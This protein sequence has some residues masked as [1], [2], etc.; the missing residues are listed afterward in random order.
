MQRRLATIFLFAIILFPLWAHGQLDRY[1]YYFKTQK[2]ITRG[3]YTG[4]IAAINIFLNNQPDDDIALYLRALAKYNLEDYRGALQDLDR[5]LLHKPFTPEAL[6]LRGGCLNQLGESRRAMGDIRLAQELRPS[7][8]HIV[9]L[10]GV[11]HFLNQAYDSAACDF[12]STLATDPDNLD[13]RLNLGIAH[14]QLGDT[15]QALADFEHARRSHPYSAAPLVNLARVYYGQKQQ[16]EA[17]RTI[18]EALA[19]EKT[20][21][22]A[23]LLRALIEHDQGKVDQAI[24]TL[25]TV[26]R[27]APRSSLALFNRAIMLTEREKLPEALADYQA[28]QEISPSNVF[29]RFNR[30]LLH[31]QL[32]QPRRA[33]EAFTAAIQLLPQFARAYSLR[34]ETRLQLGD[35][36]GAKADFDSA[37]LLV[38]KHKGG[39]LDQWSDTSRQFNRLIAFE[40]D[41]SSPADV[42][43]PSSPKSIDLLPLATVAVGAVQPYSEWRPVLRADSVCGAP[44][45]SLV[46]PRE[47]TALRVNVNLF[48]PLPNGHAVTLVHAITL[49]EANDYN[50]A[51]AQLQQLPSDGVFAPLVQYLRAIALVQNARFEPALP[52]RVS[53][54]PT[55]GD[56]ATPP[57]SSDYQEPLRIL[58]SLKRVEPTPYLDYTVGSVRFLARDL[59]GAER[60]F[61]EAIEGNPQFGEAYYNRGLVRLLLGRSEMACLDLSYAGQLGI[62]QAYRAISN[63]C[64]R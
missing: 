51:L 56:A 45:F 55:G 6:V 44:F 4:A 52:S 30:G 18:G 22:P 34:A 60:G 31:L 3:Q 21:T 26:I 15:A 41:F 29:I 48:P 23:L 58:D 35:K 64:N 37:Q 10:R 19:I 2:Q 1:Y 5:T 28:A 59:K 11:T 46:V 12:A 32:N 53:I 43:L 27:L 40:S 33:E 7:D 63:H 54:V 36:R 25:S 39:E 47:D 24:Q 42:L 17:L 14:L 13:A 61:S 50:G 20:S 9:Y 62:D 16:K 57:R 8:R 38:A 49:L